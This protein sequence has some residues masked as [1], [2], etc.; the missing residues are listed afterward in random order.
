MFS[1][2]IAKLSANPKLLFLVDSFGAVL[3]AICLGVVLPIFHEL[4][5]LPEPTL[6]LLAILACFYGSFS[7]FSYF[8]LSR[9]IKLCLRI[10]GAANLFYCCLV[11]SLIIFLFKSVTIPGLIYFSIE[12]VIIAVLAITELKLSCMLKPAN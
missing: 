10:I 1:L 5:G 3:T 9:Q 8:F 11:I 6:Y 4:I 7:V 12:V 2:L